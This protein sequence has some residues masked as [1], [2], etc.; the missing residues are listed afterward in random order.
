MATTESIDFANMTADD[1]REFDEAFAQCLRTLA[2]DLAF[3]TES[4]DN[5]QALSDVSQDE[6]DTKAAAAKPAPSN[7]LR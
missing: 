1:W 7:L 5:L 2:P 3:N 4:D 6:R